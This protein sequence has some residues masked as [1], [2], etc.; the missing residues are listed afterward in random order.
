MSYL[1]RNCINDQPLSDT[2]ER[3]S[4][5]EN[6]APCSYCESAEPTISIDQLAQIVIDPL[7]SYLE[8]GDEP[9]SYYGGYAQEGE[10]LHYVIQDELGIDEPPA[11]DLVTALIEK[12]PYD[13][14][15]GDM[16]FFQSDQL[17]QRIDL[18]PWDYQESW[19]EFSARIKHFRRFFDDE[20]RIS[21]AR[22]FGDPGSERALALPIIEIGP[23]TRVE[24]VF[25]ARR[26]ETKQD[27]EDILEEPSKNLGSPPPAITPAG[28]M[29]AAGIPVFYG[30]L[31]KETA[32]SEVRPYVGSMVVVGCF[33]PTETMHILDL[34]RIGLGF[35]GSFFAP[36]YEDR[37]T[38]LRFLESFHSII[39]RP[40]SPNNETLEYLPTQVVAEYVSNVLGIDGILFA[41][42]Q[43][44][45]IFHEYE[46]IRNQYYQELSED[47]LKQ[48]NIVLFGEAARTAEDAG[49]GEGGGA[50]MGE[51]EPGKRLQFRAGSAET[52]RVTSVSY[53]HEDLYVLKEADPIADLCGGGFN[54]PV[55]DTLF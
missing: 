31:S 11:A 26:A 20:T 52:V 14:R 13:P 39:S 41:S 5:W 50:P 37:A 27:I 8:I 15:D 4:L 51:F 55:D 54:L 24:T 43:V 30:A 34:S 38:R 1:C 23:G 33:A 49:P 40:V 18:S 28:R 36:D 47:E 21:I 9:P 48:F 22:I 45:R 6:D 32:I 10:L 44:G 42:A 16:P 46:D 7:R 19:N 29:N 12:D 53:A 25:R 2:I 35:T 3:E 17:Y